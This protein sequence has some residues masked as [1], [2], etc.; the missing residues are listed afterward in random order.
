MKKEIL[1][2]KNLIVTGFGSGLLPRSPGT[3]GSFA[4]VVAW[5]A[6]IY[7]IAGLSIQLTT[8]LLALFV[9]IIGWGATHYYIRGKESHVDP[10]EVVIDEWA[11]MYVALLWV[12]SVNFGKILIAFLLFRFFDILKPWL[13]SRAEKAPGATGIMLDD[14]VAGAFACMTGVIAWNLYEMFFELN[15]P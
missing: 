13:V 1:T 10:Q 14:L 5:L 6:I 4:A 7:S 9:S 2:M 11:G 15:Q 12:S 8:I 3:F